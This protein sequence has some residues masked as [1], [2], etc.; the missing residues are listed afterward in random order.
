MRKKA[1]FLFAIL[2]ILMVG[3]VIPPE[4]AAIDPD[5]QET[6]VAIARE[7]YYPNGDG[8]GTVEQA[9]TYHDLFVTPDHVTV[10]FHNYVNIHDE[11]AQSTEYHVEWFIV[12]LEKIGDELI[13]VKTIKTGEVYYSPP[14]NINHY[15]TIS[16]DVN[17]N[18]VG[19]H[20]YCVGST[21]KWYRVNSDKSEELIW[22]VTYLGHAYVHEIADPPPG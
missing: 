8:G 13:H 6:D 14:D 2:A 22:D 3:L 19:T 9:P 5:L 4:A 12:V 1:N 20:H 15:Q 17:Y 7:Y 16:I 18:G 11:R 21:F 10:T